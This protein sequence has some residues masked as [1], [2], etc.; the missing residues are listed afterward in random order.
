MLAQVVG[1]L[2]A[3]MLYL[4]ASGGPS[5]DVSA[6]FASNGYGAHSPGGYSLGAALLIEILL[7]FAFLTVILNVTDPRAPAGFAPLAIGLCLTLI[8]LISIPVTNTSVKPG[9]QHRAGAVRR[10]LGAGAALAVLGGPI[11]GALLA[12]PVYRWFARSA[13]DTVAA[14][15]SAVRS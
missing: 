12:G 5:F 8:H 2:A 4:A 14:P 3:G 1:A 15:K 7:T 13:P 10:R 9:A 11:A 6:G